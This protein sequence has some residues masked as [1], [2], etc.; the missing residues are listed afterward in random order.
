MADNSRIPDSQ[1]T[2]I[3][4]SLGPFT[5]VDDGRPGQSTSKSKGKRSLSAVQP[6]AGL[7]QAKRIKQEKAVAGN[8]SADELRNQ[9]SAKVIKQEGLSPAALGD[10]GK[11]CIKRRTKYN[12]VRRGLPPGALELLNRSLTSTSAILTGVD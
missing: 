11:K 4:S 10:S 9:A 2:D 3:A 5:Y 7:S 6:S 1:P 8:A 12:W